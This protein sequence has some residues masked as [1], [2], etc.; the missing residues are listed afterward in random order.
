MEFRRLRA[1]DEPLL[2]DMLMDFRK[3]CTS[4]TRAGNFLS[5]GTNYIFACIN[6]HKVIGFVLGYRLPRFDAQADRLYIHEVGVFKE[7]KRQGIGKKL[8]EMTL[9][10]CRDEGLSKAFLITNKSNTA[11]NKLYLGANGNADNDDDIVYY[12]DSECPEGI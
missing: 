7:Y 9:N 1:G 2:A 10:L 6:N 8:M 11:A 3:E 4:L 5:S 12:F